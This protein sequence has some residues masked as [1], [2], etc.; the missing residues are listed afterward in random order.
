[1]AAVSRGGRYD[2][3][4][5]AVTILSETFPYVAFKHWRFDMA[6]LRSFFFFTLPSY[7]SWEE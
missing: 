4:G 2:S 3:F 6:A 1:M 5:T 7:F